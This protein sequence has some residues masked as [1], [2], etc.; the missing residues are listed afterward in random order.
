M[1]TR[2]ERVMVMQVRSLLL[3]VLREKLAVRKQ[4]LHTSNNA[5]NG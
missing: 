1:T 3:E 5:S 2:E 4:E